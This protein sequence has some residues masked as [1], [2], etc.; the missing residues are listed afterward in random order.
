MDHRTVSVPA[1]QEEVVQKKNRSFL[2]Q[3][4]LRWYQWY[5]HRLKVLA[6]LPSSTTPQLDSV[7]FLTH[8]PNDVISPSAG[9]NFQ[10]EI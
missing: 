9:K 3:P 1:C 6:L 4:F 10:S 7:I 5:L 8:L 2:N